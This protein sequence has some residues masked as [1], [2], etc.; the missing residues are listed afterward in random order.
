MNAS[1]Q[2]YR[3]LAEDLYTIR[4]ITAFVGLIKPGIIRLSLLPSLIQ[5]MSPALKSPVPVA[6]Q[7][8]TSCIIYPTGKVRSLLRKLK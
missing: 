2:P 6:T 4:N 7:T 8:C 3:L 5:C 1:E